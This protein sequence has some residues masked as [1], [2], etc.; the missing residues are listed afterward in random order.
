MKKHT[1]TIV[2]VSLAV[3]AALALV[4]VIVQTAGGGV[5]VVATQSIASFQAVLKAIPD[6]VRAD[7]EHGG[8][9]L[10][11][12]DGEASF[13]WSRDF[14]HSARYDVMLTWDAA[15]FRNAGLD[16]TK[17]PAEYTA[18][19]GMLMLGTKLGNSALAYSGEATPIASYEKLVAS[20]PA[21][22]NYHMAMDHFGVKVGNGNLFEWARNL[23]ANTATQTAQDQD[24]VF[25]LLNPEPLIAAG[26]DPAKVEGWDYT[27]VE[28]M[29]NNATVKV[30]RF[31]KSY[32]IG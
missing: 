25:V 11:S 28:V 2:A 21:V 17:L 20:Y 9:V 16:V 7:D 5:D 15:P 18:Y 1:K 10:R 19:A 26:V 8:W 13:F 23:T 32:H 12:P 6:Q 31:L 3:A 22:L 30:Y 24:M 27:Q 29:Q 14:A 4:G